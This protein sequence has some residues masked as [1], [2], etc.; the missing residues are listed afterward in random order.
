VRRCAWI[1]TRDVAAAKDLV[2]DCIARA[3]E[4]I[5]VWEEGTDLRA[6][7]FTINTSATRY[8]VQAAGA[9]AASGH[10]PMVNDGEHP[11]QRVQN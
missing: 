9:L 11:R 4:K 2:Q 8:L 6:W 1:L 3:L 7:M 5:D 10:P